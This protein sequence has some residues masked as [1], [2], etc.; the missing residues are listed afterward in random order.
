MLNF[1]YLPSSLNVFSISSG[2]GISSV[3]SALAFKK[4]FFFRYLC[5]FFYR[6]AVFRAFRL[7]NSSIFSSYSSTASESTMLLL[8]KFS[9]DDR[10]SSSSSNVSMYTAAASI[11]F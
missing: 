11:L 4:S 7:V 8:S 6:T 1:D 2:K 9:D 10:H 3:L 5:T